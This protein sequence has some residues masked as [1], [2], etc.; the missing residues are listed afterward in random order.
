MKSVKHHLRR[1][2]GEQR[3]SF[4]ELATLLTGMKAC[5]NSRPLLPLSDDPEDPAALTPGHFLIGKPLL[6]VPEPSLEELPVSRL[7]RWQLVQQIQQHFCRRWSR[8]YLNSLQTRGKWLRDEP[9]I[10]TGSLCLVKSE[11]LPPTQWLL[12]RVVQV[13]PGPDESTRVATLRTSTSQLLRPVH[14]LIPRGWTLY[15]TNTC[16]F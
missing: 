6:A 7:S 12:A 9:P 3:L 14:K 16:L 10:K 11:V 1:L 5:L 8:E 2:I 4:E 13:H 15:V